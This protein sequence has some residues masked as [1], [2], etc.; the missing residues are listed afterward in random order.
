MTTVAEA[1]QEQHRKTQFDIIVIYNGVPKEIKVRHDETVAQVLNRAVAAFAP[2]PQPHTMS[3]F[4][5]AGNELNDAHTVDQAGIR[6]HDKLL[7]RPSA[8][9]G[10]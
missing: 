10:G 7:M 1:K 6:E 9:K 3:L 5:E 2:L 4:N 8:V